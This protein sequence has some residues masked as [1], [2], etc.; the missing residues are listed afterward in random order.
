MIK[1][2]FREDRLALFAESKTSLEIYKWHSAYKILAEE[3]EKGE[4][5]IIESDVFT[6]E[7]IETI[8][9]PKVPCNQENFGKYV[10][11]SECAYCHVGHECYQDTP[12]LFKE[13]TS[14]ILTRDF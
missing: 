6:V 2:T 3:L 12:L 5:I 13:E 9:E 11:G 1:I 14:N 8:T 7:S 4:K 10:Q